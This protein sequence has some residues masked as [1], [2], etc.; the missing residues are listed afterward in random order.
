MLNNKIRI[1]GGKWRGRKLSFP[2][3]DGLRPTP[4]RVRETLFNW[5]APVIQGAHC[6]D[7][8]AGSGALGFEALSRGAS[9]VIFVDDNKKIIN[10]L[11]TNQALLNAQTVQII[12]STAKDYLKE[13]IQPF[14]IVFLDPPFHQGLIQTYCALLDQYHLMKPNSYVYIETEVNLK[15]L[16]LPNSWKLK[17]NKKAGNVYYGLLIN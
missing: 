9:E 12:Y 10:Q 2:N 1:I 17:K 13:A 14:D 8:F 16:V 15:S 5:L 3:I 4:N 6:L 7:L 11:K